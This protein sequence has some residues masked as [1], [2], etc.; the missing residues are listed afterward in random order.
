MT[1]NPWY[2]KNPILF[3]TLQLEISN[4]Y[5]NLHFSVRNDTVFLSGSFPLK[6]GDK[7][8]D[9][10]LIEV[11]FPPKYPR[12][13][14]LVYE[15]GGRIPR[16]I[17]RHIFPTGDACLFF[18]LQL[19]DVYPAGA[20]LLDFLK[21]PVQSYF[22]SQ[23]Y[24]ELTGEWLLGEWPHGEDAIY[25]YYGSILKTKERTVISKYLQVISRKEIKG[26]WP[27]PCGSGKLLRRCHLDEVAKLNRDYQYAM[28]QWGWRNKKRKV[29]NIK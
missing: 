26:H 11:E 17:D 28:D 1:R 29:D 12:G 14:P 13:V 19:S 18:P 23:S 21:G 6:D 15:I 22:V 25:D 20:S 24:F 5:P 27:C 4:T 9:R 7:I 3:R 16:T 2:K 10:F 8:V